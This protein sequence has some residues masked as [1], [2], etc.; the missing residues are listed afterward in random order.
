MRP[1]RLPYLDSGIADHGQ[2][3]VPGAPTIGFTFGEED[4]PLRGDRLQLLHAIRDGRGTLWPPEPP[5]P[6][7]RHAHVR[8]LFV[9]RLIVVRDGDG[10]DALTNDLVHA[11]G[12]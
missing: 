1:V 9:A 4:P 6:V 2:R 12:L 3:G 8:R 10:R 7:E 5:V 11:E